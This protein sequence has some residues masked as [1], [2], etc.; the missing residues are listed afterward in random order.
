MSWRDVFACQDTRLPD[1]VPSVINDRRQY[2]SP[3]SLAIRPGL[4]LSLSVTLFLFPSHL[5]MYAHSLYVQLCAHLLNP[6][7]NATNDASASYG[8]SGRP[9]ISACV[10][11]ASQVRWENPHLWGV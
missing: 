10:M 5:F 7:F 4:F 3:D 1:F 9:Q 6:S 11:A 2:Y 8:V